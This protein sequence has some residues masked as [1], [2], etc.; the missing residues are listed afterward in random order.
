MA[1]LGA[2]ILKPEIAIWR[3]AVQPVFEKARAKYGSDVDA[4]LADVEAI[5]KA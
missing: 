4:I 1:G 5:R 2:H 3:A